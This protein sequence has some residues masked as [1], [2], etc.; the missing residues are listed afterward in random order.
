MHPA[1]CRNACHFAS[2][3]GESE[4]ESWTMNS[5][6]S[7]RTCDQST[8]L[9][10]FFLCC[11][12]SEDAHKPNIRCDNVWKPRTDLK[13]LAENM[14]TPDPHK[15]MLWKRWRYKLSVSAAAI[16]SVI[17]SLLAQGPGD[18]SSAEKA[19]V[20]VIYGCCNPCNESPDVYPTP[21]FLL[22]KEP[23]PGVLNLRRD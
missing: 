3:R 6:L 16:G 12:P 21:Y 13:I 18:L 14:P 2:S 15:L 8:S 19:V 17:G 9:E 23:G 11:C 20:T 22:L 5:S 7:E 4:M 1:E 10:S